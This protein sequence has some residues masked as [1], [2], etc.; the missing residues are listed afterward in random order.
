M[1]SQK[2][3]IM[4]FIGL[5]LAGFCGYQL[6]RIYSEGADT[7]QTKTPEA[8]KGPGVESKSTPNTTSATKPNTPP[9]EIPASE[10]LKDGEKGILNKMLIAKTNGSGIYDTTLHKVGTTKAG[11]ELGKA[12]KADVTGNGSYNIKYQDKDGNFRIVNSVSVNAKG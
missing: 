4:G 10:A 11:T 8:P 1:A 2:R 7:P 5:G 3:I 9:V 12:F 6:Y